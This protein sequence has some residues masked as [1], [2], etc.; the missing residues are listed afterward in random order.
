MNLSRKISLFIGALV[1]FIAAGMGVT[2]MAVSSKV[3]SQMAENFL[4]AQADMGAKLVRSTVSSQLAVLQE[5]ANRLSTKTMVWE[6]Q[7]ESLAPDIKR[8]GYE[9]FAIVSP[10]GFASYILGDTTAA[11]GD[12]DYVHTALSG[13]QAISD[14]IFV[15]ETGK[16][17]VMLAVPITSDGAVVGLLVG[18]KNGKSL[19]DITDTMGFGKTGFAYLINRKGAMIA[20]RDRSLVMRQFAPNEAAR[21][22]KAY[23]SMADA[24][25]TMISDKKGIADYSD[26][27]TDFLCGFEPVRDPDWL[28]AVAMDKRELM[29]GIYFL[30]GVVILGTLLFL[31]LGIAVAV[32]IGRSVSG[33]LTK[34]L[35]VLETISN[36]DLTGRLTIDSG[37]ELGLVARKFNTSIG[38]LARMVSTTKKSSEKLSDIVN[39][40]SANMTETA[41]SMDQIAANISSIKHRALDQSASVTQTNSTMVAIKDHSE[42]LDSLIEK[43]A[44]SVEASSAAIEE[45]V[46]SIQSVTEIL[47]GNFVSVEELLKIS[48]IGKF[49]LEEVM[50][51][52]RTVERDSEGLF[53]ASAMIQNLAEQTKLLGMNA[54]IEAAHAGESGKG[55][56]VVADEIRKLAEDSSSQGGAISR[57]LE[58][59][60]AR[61]DQV[62][63]LSDKSQRQFSRI[64][65]LLVRVRDQESAIKTA[66]E[67]QDEGSSQI[68]KAIGDIHDITALVKDG[69]KQMLVGS[70]EVHEEMGHLTDITL[71]ISNGMDEMAAGAEQI[72]AAVQNVNKITQDTRSNISD[73]YAEVE[74][75][76]VAP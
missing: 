59:L 24:F 33:P 16:L 41:S 40:L 2:A 46:A 73:L 48:E 72:N 50:G 8:L 5:L 19:S 18:T 21:T 10:T 9:D 43:Q 66:M 44:A 34:M 53:E 23:S 17:V 30:S 45:M 58:G 68:L 67:S 15:K 28:L 57:D 22:N 37:D 56:A 11:L 51:I 20:H 13:A 35:P 26:A 47:Q 60:K 74:K 64:F 69:S 49:G 31:A 61:I 25:N 62:V 71:E 54:A 55:F 14:V 65:D 36:G 4:L 75:F 29:A 1:V 12:R 32:I 63:V 27:G 76:N 42:R 7:K 6:M 39:D 38:S 3:V 70:A 52:V